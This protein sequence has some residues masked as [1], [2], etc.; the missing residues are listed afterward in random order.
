ME[1]K[2]SCIRATIPMHGT[3]ASGTYADVNLPRAPWQDGEHLKADPRHETRPRRTLMVG[4]SQKNQIEHYNGQIE[5]TI[6]TIRALAAEA[7]Q[8]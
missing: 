8:S 1:S 5:R 4:A 2:A 6:E 3:S 7:R